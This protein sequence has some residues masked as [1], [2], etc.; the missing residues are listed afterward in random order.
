[1]NEFRYNNSPSAKGHPAYVFGKTQ[2][3]YK[4][5]GLTSNSKDRERKIKLPQNPEPNKNSDSF[6]RVKPVT[7]NQKYYSEPLDWS[8]S[9]EDMGIIRH[10][11]KDYKR[12][13]YRHKKKK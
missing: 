4:S 7:H 13:A 12:R 2:K 3:M 9:K 10:L 6:V 8:F 1:M 11:I 5:F